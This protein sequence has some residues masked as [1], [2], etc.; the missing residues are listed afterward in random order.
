MRKIEYPNRQAAKMWYQ[1]LVNEKIKFKFEIRWKG[2]VF[3]S[4]QIITQRVY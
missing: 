2:D 4:P 3:V 1:V